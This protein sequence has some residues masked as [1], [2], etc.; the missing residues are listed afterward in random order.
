MTMRDLPVAAPDLRARA[1]RLRRAD[2]ARRA[3][4]A[5]GARPFPKDLPP[6][7][8]GLAQW[9]LDPTHP[10]TARVIVNRYWALFFGRGLVATPADFGSQGRL[11]T[12]PELLDWLATQFVAVGLGPEGAAAAAS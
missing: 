7:R 5:R 10:L 3:G 9:L 4:H 8:L 11:P 2:R 1:R 12:H 6:N